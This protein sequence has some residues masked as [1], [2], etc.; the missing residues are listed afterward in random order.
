MGELRVQLAGARVL[1]V[2]RRAARRVIF[3]ATG[4]VASKYDREQS[5]FRELDT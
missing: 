2:A 5:T 3:S 1:K 4:G